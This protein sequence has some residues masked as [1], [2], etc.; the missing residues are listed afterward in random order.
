MRDTWASGVCNVP[1][2]T[3]RLLSALTL[4]KHDGHLIPAFNKSALSVIQSVI[5]GRNFLYQWIYSHHTVCYFDHILQKTLK[6]VFKSLSPNSNPDKLIS[7]IFSHGVFEKPATCCG[8]KIYLPTD[9]DITALM[10]ASLKNTP[11]PHELLSR[12]PK[13]IPLW[14]TRAEFEY[15]FQKK[16]TPNLREDIIDHVRDHLKGVLSS[17]D[18][19]QVLTL[20]LPGKFVNI[21]EAEIYVSLGPNKPVKFVEVVPAPVSNNDI[22]SSFHYVFIPRQCDALK[23]KCISAIKR[24]HSYQY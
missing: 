14:K 2:D 19:K 3:T 15:I 20:R 24:A 5:E 22:V 6:G 12:R 23:D 21:K 9:G 8:H 11:E 17:K 13:L 7:I 1:I 18:L 10:K 4:C 16:T